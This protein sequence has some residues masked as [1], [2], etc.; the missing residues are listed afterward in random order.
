MIGPMTPLTATFKK[1]LALHQRGR[2]ADAERAYAQVLR[3]Q[4]AHFDALHLMGVVALQTGRSKR[5]VELI[6]QA[7][8]VNGRVA[9]AH[10]NRGNGL[11]A[12]Q[13][14]EEAIASY[15]RAIAL[16][17]AYAGAHDNR[18]VA[19]AVLGRHEEA[20]TCHDRAIALKPDLADAH[21]NRGNVLLSLERPE[22]ALASFDRAI[23]LRPDFADAHYNRGNTLRDLGRPADAIAS[24]DQAIALRPDFRW[25]HYNRGNALRDL[26]RH[27]EAITSY[28]SAVALHADFAEAHWNQ[29]L[30][31]LALGDYERG[32]AQHEWRWRAELA[33]ARPDL[34]GRPWLGDSTVDGKTVLVVAEQ[35]LG[36]SLQF[37][38][39]ATL[40]GERARVVLEVPRTLRR[41]L[42]GMPGVS[43]VVAAGDARPPFDVWT[44]MMSLPLAF[45]T[46]CATI[47]S[48]VPYLRANPD[49]VEAWRG[50]VASMPGRK[51]GLVWAGSAR[52]GD[53]RGN[54]L[55]SRR[56][57]T[58][59]HLAPLAGIPGLC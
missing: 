6:D 44:S 13:R 27:E 35:G 38:R 55:D 1:G 47:P 15:D 57:V 25:T 33:H 10:G 22:E 28:S 42:D 39:Y 45:R 26:Q 4:P 21:F 53:P 16:D 56:S 23:A 19:L 3:Q 7:I 36:D 20:L 31:Y 46:T 40:L 50:R 59:Q 8:K 34:P 9:A 2:F 52:L 58:L 14:P 51:V 5:G 17:P 54:S 12:L 32:W 30:C 29:S 18:G 49:Q 37:C 11:S 41:L 43:Q 24:Y 48:A